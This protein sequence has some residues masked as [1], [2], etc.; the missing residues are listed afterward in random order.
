MDDYI[1]FIDE[2]SRRNNGPLNRP[3]GAPRKMAP[4]D[5]GGS[6]QVGLRIPTAEFDQLSELS[7]IYG[8]RPATMARMLVLSAVR[9]AR[10]Q[11]LENVR[12]QGLRWL[13]R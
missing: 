1:D 9:A 2:I 10:E 8:V 12:V 13:S 7:R 4:A 3:P 6:V 11:G 5:G